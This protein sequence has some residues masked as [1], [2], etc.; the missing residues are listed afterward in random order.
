MKYNA[1]QKIM[2][3]FNFQYAGLIEIHICT[4][5]KG[6]VVASKGFEIDIFGKFKINKNSRIRKVHQDLQSAILTFSYLVNRICLEYDFFK[7]NYF[8]SQEFSKDTIIKD[9][10]VYT[11][12]FDENK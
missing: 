1:E 8:F 3:L 5:K 11:P 6:F 4:N 12:T 7:Q 2:Q 9:L 10:N